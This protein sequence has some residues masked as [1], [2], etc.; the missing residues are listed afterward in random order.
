MCVFE[1]AEEEVENAVI[2]DPSEEASRKDILTEYIK[3]SFS[4]ICCFYVMEGRDDFFCIINGDGVS[5]EQFRQNL[6]NQRDRMKKN[7][8][9]V[10]GLFC[11]FYLSEDYESLDD[12]HK[13]YEQVKRKYMNK[14]IQDKTE[15]SENCSIERIAEIIRK[16]L[17]DAN[18]SVNGIAEQMDVSPSHLSRYFKNKMGM[19]VLEYIHQCR[20]EMAKDMLRNS[21]EIRIREVANL[22]GF[23]NITTFIRVFKKIEGVTPGQ[24]REMLGENEM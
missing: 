24:Y 19:G 4:G 21:P 20:V 5:S 23:Y 16:N 14:E 12:I 18:L 22:T 7:L 1:E 6:S 15:E 2:D 11:N 9:E 13:G 10:E 17:S 3:E 8:A